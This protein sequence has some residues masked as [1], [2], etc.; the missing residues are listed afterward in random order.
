MRQNEESVEL[1]LRTKRWDRMKKKNFNFEF[2]VSKK[3]AGK[4][5]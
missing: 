3:E 5:L 4:K 2:R 1:G